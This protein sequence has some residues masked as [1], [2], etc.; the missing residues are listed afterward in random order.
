M[1]ICILCD[2]VVNVE[3]NNNLKKYCLGMDY[4]DVYCHECMENLYVNEIADGYR[5]PDGS[6][7]K[8]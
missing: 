6:R 8:K 2:N 4:K 7:K 5:N 3:E 1:A